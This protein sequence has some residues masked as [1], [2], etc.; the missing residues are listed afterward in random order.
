MYMYRYILWHDVGSRNCPV[1]GFEG[2]LNSFARGKPRKVARRRQFVETAVNVEDLDADVAQLDSDLATLAKH[3]LLEQSD[4]TEEDFP[5][6]VGDVIRASVD[7]RQL[8]LELALNRFVRDDV[9]LQVQ[10]RGQVVDH[11]LRVES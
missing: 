2:Q 3:R 8:P 11:V 9:I 5:R 4:R 6:Q 10:V 7:K 1:R